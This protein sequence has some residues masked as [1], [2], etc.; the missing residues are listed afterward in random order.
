[1]DVQEIENAI[2]QLPRAQLAELATWFEQLHAQLWD[3]QIEQ[4]VRSGR[5]DALLDETARDLDSGAANHCETSGVTSIL[6]SLP[7]TS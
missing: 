1:M 2:S 4:D 5:L 6:A 7:S 3:A